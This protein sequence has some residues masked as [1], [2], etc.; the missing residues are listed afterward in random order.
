MKSKTE[1]V[2]ITTG[3]GRQGRRTQESSMGFLTVA[4]REENKQREDQ[5]LRITG[6]ALTAHSLE[7]VDMLGF[8]KSHFPYLFY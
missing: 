6:W 3:E 2:E 5:H 4:S 8:V 1:T 7:S